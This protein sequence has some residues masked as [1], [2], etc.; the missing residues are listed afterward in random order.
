MSTAPVRSFTRTTAERQGVH[1]VITV[2]GDIDAANADEIASYATNH[3]EPGRPLVIDLTQLEFFGT[4]GVSALHTIEVRCTAGDIR[5][6]V[7]AEGA[8]ARV[9]RICDPQGVLP[10]VTT[11]V[12]AKGRTEMR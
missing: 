5:W 1:V 8:V 7:A 12:A 6:A 4:A 2:E 10:V 11:L 3:A 9:L